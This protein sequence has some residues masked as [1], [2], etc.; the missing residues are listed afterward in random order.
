MSYTPLPG[1]S[2]VDVERALRVA[3]QRYNI[4]GQ[5]DPCLLR[6]SLGL[7]IDQYN[8]SVDARTLYRP[9]YQPG[10]FAG[11]D[12]LYSVGAILSREANERPRTFA[13]F[14]GQ[15]FRSPDSVMRS[16]IPMGQSPECS[17]QGVGYNLGM[18]HQ[19][20]CPTSIPGQCTPLR[21]ISTLS[22]VD[23]MTSN[24]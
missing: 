1:Q 4:P 3:S 24:Y 21:G 7:T 8:R 15:V 13:Q 16:H 11:W 6:N 17:S 19:S 22:S 10:I 23:G 20:C 9:Q 14:S 2:S 18:Q 5:Y 12:Q